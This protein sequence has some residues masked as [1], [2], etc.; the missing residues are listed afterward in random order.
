MSSE[1]RQRL[2]LD[3]GVDPVRWERVVGLIME[4]ARPELER[5]ASEASPVVV[6]LGW[7]RPVLAMA[8]SIAALCGATLMARAAESQV[9]AEVPA[10]AEAL[11]PSSVAAW[12]EGGQAPTLE[13]LV[14]SMAGEEGG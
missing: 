2:P 12:L 11:V 4:E 7:T 8:A 10:I 1:R 14:L 3:P 13:E 6:L 5:R 9:E